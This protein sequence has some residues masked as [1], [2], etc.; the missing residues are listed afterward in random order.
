MRSIKALFQKTAQSHPYW[1]SF[2]TFSTAIA[3]QHFSKRSIK[4]WFNKL[5]NPEDYSRKE[6]SAIFRHLEKL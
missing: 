5:V 3:E 2:V 1:S 4:L 6:K